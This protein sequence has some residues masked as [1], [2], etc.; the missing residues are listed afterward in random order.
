MDC[1]RTD[2]QRFLEYS[3]RS[4]GQL[5]NKVISLGYSQETAEALVE[6]AV[7]YRFVDD[8]RFC[9]L[10]AASKNMG[11]LRLRIEL[12]KRGVTENA[13]EDYLSGISDES[14]FE[15]IVA[16]V[17]K[18]YSRIPHRDTALRRAA[19]WLGRRGYSGEFIHRV[20]REAL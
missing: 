11:K 9:E 14:D 3:E 4:T 2:S 15:E 18:K 5:R 19:G 7:K 20:L 1:A 17:R 10:Y 13:V 8:C 16:S 12:L 6:W